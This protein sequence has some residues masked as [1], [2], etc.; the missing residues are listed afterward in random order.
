MAELIALLPAELRHRIIGA[1]GAAHIGRWARYVEINAYLSRFGS[2]STWRALDDSTFEFPPACP[3]LIPC[4]PNTGV[5]QAE[6]SAVRRW[7]SER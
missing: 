2:T 6:L 7:A 3:E 4:D 1:T 5:A